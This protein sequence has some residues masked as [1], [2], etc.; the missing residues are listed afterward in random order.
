L[1]LCADFGS[2]YTIVKNTLESIGFDGFRL[3]A[4]WTEG[5]LESALLPV[6]LTVDGELQTFWCDAETE[7]LW[8]LRLELSSGAHNRPGAFHF[9]ARQF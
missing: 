1:N 7:S 6:K 9:L 8:E 4:T 3:G 2:L 5:F